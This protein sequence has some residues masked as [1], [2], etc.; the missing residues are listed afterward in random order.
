MSGLSITVTSWATFDEIY[1]ERSDTTTTVN[2][3]FT[4]LFY[5]YLGLPMDKSCKL[6]ITFPTEMPLTSDLLS[7][8]GI[9]SGIFGTWSLQSYT[10]SNNYVEIKGCTVAGIEDF[11]DE[12]VFLSA[13]MNPNQVKTTDTFT[14]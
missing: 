5:F 9:S 10:V 14:V 7:A 11:Y 3:I 2:E 12:I 6:K 1:F 13:V 8:Y 4:G